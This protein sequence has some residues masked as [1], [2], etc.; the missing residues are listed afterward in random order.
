MDIEYSKRVQ[1]I[2]PYLFAQIEKIKA[3]KRAQGVDLIALGIGDPDL[4]TP[5]FIIDALVEEARRDENHKY[6][7][8]EGE[9]D[10]R[11]AVARWVK[12]RFGV[13]ID[14]DTQITCMSGSKE[15]IAN[16]AR[17]FVNPSDKVLCPDPAYPVYSQGAT[18]LCDGEPAFMALLAE[19]NFLP[20]LDDAEK[21]AKNAKMIYLNYPNNPTGAVSDNAFM[22]KAAA[23]AEK[24]NL[25]YCY[26]N[27]YSEFTFDEYCSPSALE[28]TQNCIEFHSLSK[29]FNMTGDRVGFAIG[30]AALVGGLKKVK[31]N[32]DSGTPMYVQRAAIVALESYSGK[33]PPKEV[34][35]NMK[36]YEKRR[37]V[38][39][40]GLRQLGFNATKPKA[41]FYLW[42][43][44]GGTPA[45][46]LVTKLLDVGVVATPG[47]GFGPNGEGFVRFALTQPIPRIKEA[48]ERMQK[49]F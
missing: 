30:D 47:T 9:N 21:Q 16:V 49:I 42:V 2:P 13:E 44:T 15:G 46:E 23:F 39:A 5:Q 45:G 3:Q 35:E 48:L 34:R 22:E 26:D 14:S 31:S 37:D 7:S 4:P 18:M 8:S 6:P 1:R 17:A 11:E 25:V 38:L 43:P 36:E 12:G 28:F 24:H 27:A 20:N 29:T 41:T 40:G 32:I 19:N 33:Q 10:F